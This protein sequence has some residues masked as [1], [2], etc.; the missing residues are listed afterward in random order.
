[1]G[2]GVGGPAPAVPDFGLAG[3][4]NF[5]GDEDDSDNSAAE[6][7]DT[8]Q[9]SPPTRIRTEFPETWLWMDYVAE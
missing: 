1:M 7:S 6:S 5:R 3:G 9:N 8:N 4:A 2:G